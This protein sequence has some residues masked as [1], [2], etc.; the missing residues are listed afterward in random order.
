[1]TPNPATFMCNSFPGMA[2]IICKD[3]S[4]HAVEKDGGITTLKL[5]DL[6]TGMSQHEIVGGYIYATVTY[7][8]DIPHDPPSGR[9]ECTSGEATDIT[10]YLGKLWSRVEPPI[11]HKNVTRCCRIPPV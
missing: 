10:F 2:L 11:L 1:M 7:L 4:A 6:P 8:G 5:Q 3:K 9:P